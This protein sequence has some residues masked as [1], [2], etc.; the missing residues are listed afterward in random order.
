MFIVNIVGVDE[1]VDVG[2]ANGRIQCDQI[3]Q[4]LARYGIHVKRGIRRLRI[5][6]HNTVI[7]HSHRESGEGTPCSELR[8]YGA[9]KNEFAE[10][11]V[12]PSYKAGQGQDRQ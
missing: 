7:L 5:S 3:K 9:T 1:S 12:R 8:A 4:K 6:F 10:S 11:F 2:L